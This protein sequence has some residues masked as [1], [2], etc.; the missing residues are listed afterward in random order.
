M[1]DLASNRLDLGAIVLAAPEA[2]H[3]RSAQGLTEVDLG[4]LGM[5]GAER[6]QRG[7]AASAPA[8]GR[9]RRIA[10]AGD[11]AVRGDRGEHP[12]VGDPGVLELVREH[13]PEALADGR[14]D[15]GPPAEQPD[16]L[17][18]QLAAVQ[19]A[20]VAEDP[21]VVRVELGELGLALGVLALGR[22]RRRAALR[23]R[24]LA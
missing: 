8:P 14:G 15:V 23:G 7:G 16:Q 11:V 6:G 17:E 12:P 21:V 5:L 24:P 19:A 9:L 3:A 22:G 2:G 1:L 10:G 13:L 20:R 4:G 18:H